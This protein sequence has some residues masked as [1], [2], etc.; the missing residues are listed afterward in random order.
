MFVPR[1][2][3]SSI[4]FIIE[5]AIDKV[6]IIETIAK[7]RGA[8]RIHKEKKEKK[9][10]RRKEDK[11]RREKRKRKAFLLFSNRKK[12]KEERKNKEKSSNT[13][14]GIDA[15]QETS[16]KSLDAILDA[17][18][19]PPFRGGARHKTVCV[20]CECSLYDIRRVCWENV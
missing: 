16:N 7:R 2:S 20:T 10:E 1:Q 19:Q 15:T 3:Q 4:L 11:E 6:K 8:C 18:R 13:L 12:E 17:L 14:Q 9:K 5:M